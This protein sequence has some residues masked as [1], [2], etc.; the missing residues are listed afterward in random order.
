MPLAPMKF[1]NRFDEKLMN[2]KH[3]YEHQRTLYTER[4]L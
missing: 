4:I 3:A 2:I 1:Q